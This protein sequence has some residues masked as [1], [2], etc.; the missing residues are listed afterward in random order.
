MIV[1]PVTAMSAIA[2]GLGLV[3]KFV[4]LVR[5]ARKGDE[6]PYRVE[7]KQEG[8]ALVILRDGEVK[9]RVQP[10]QLKLNEWDGPRFEALRARVNSL[11]GQ[12]NGLYAQLPNLSVDEQVR[13]QQRM[14]QMKQD[15]CRDFREMMNISERVLGVPLE[16]HYTLYTT[17]S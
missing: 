13:L 9:E 12:F 11:W 7:A 17:C 6:R 4:D 10:D 3:D 2:A 16:D 1:D 15:L 5:K 14:N 8:G